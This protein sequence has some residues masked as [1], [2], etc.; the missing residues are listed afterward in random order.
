MQVTFVRCALVL[1]IATALTGCRSAAPSNWNIPFVK[2]SS[3][4]GSAYAS[5]PS[6][7]SAGAAPGNYAQPG[8]QQPGTPNAALVGAPYPSGQP[9]N[10]GA[11]QPNVVQGSPYAP[12]QP[13]ATTA[14][15]P[16]AGPYNEAYGQAPPT[17]QANSAAPAQ[18]YNA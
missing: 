4:A 8:A 17:A 13:A 12:G 11:A 15:A 9:A 2:K 18:P 7:P 10:Y 16:Q 14:M 1:A 6:L 5:T 3:P